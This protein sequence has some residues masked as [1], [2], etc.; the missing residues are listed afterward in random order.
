MSNNPFSTEGYEF[1]MP[2][3]LYVEEGITVIIPEFLRI[4]VEKS[5]IGIS[6]ELQYRLPP[7]PWA[8]M[9]QI[10][11][12]KGRLTHMLP[13]IN[14]F[15]SL[16]LQLGLELNVK[17][18]QVVLLGKIKLPHMPSPEHIRLPLQYAIPFPQRM[19]AWN[20]IKWNETQMDT[21]LEGS[22]RCRNI[23]QATAQSDPHTR[24]VLEALLFLTGA[25]DFIN[26]SVSKARDIA[27]DLEK[28]TGTKSEVI[29]AL[30]FQIGGQ[31]VI[32]IG[33]GAGLYL[34]TEGGLGAYGAFELSFGFIAG[35]GLSGVGSIFWSAN[36]KKAFENFTGRSELYAVGAG[37]DVLGASVAFYR[38][39]TEGGKK[40][41]FTG[42][43]ITLTV[44][45]GLPVMFMGGNAWTI[46]THPYY[47]KSLDQDLD[48]AEL[49]M[50]GDPRAVPVMPL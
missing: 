30:G 23:P 26:E 7:F 16:I 50:A 28:K 13:E 11:L 24:S 40:Y 29:L 44:G 34:T 9:G 37:V 6:C 43:S 4:K 19:P 1:V 25:E 22:Q 21:M 36:G 42:M 12:N 45:L 35:I 39:P 33:G 2:D 32:G 46:A 27:G 18:C 47:P 3:S 38:P 10:I 48:Y 5:H 15:D 8:S 17:E 31:F 14:I 49:V 20:N 41:N